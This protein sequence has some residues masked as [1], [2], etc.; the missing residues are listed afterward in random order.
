MKLVITGALGHIGSRLIHSLLPG[1][2]SEV[3]LI[4]NLA[5]QRYSSL[6]N[7]PAGVPFRFVEADVLGAD[8]NQLFSGAD[9]VVHL[10]AITN[11]AGSFDIQDQVERVN[12][13]GTE[14]VARACLVNGSRLVFLS[15]TSVYGTA[16][17]VVGEDCPESD[18]KPQ[19]PYAQSKLRA[20]KLLNEL[21]SKAGLRSISCR[22]GT[23]Y[24]S[25]I[26]MRF[27]TAVNKFVWQACLGQPISVWRT[28][29]HQKRPY[30]ELGDA[31]RALKFILARDLF[32][33]RVYNVLTDNLTVSQIVDAIR[34]FVPDLS[35]ELVD[36]RIMN[37]LSYE[38]ARDRFLGKG[39][40]YQ[41]QIERAI[42]ESV[43]LIRNVRRP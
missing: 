4:D 42:G 43:A 40:Q 10:A 13:E 30:L 6:F 22:F 26:G 3:L 17:E 16:S 24:G 8:L 32:D 15:T 5:T 11:A 20:E 33:G 36:A 28:A 21:N 7:L 9:A 35:M 14:R 25:S 18:L 29:L 31:V 38:V 23:I 37:Q 34:T 27:H 2:F 39:F 19:S 41:G 12:Y 1:E